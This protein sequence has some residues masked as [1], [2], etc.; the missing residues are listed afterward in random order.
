MNKS[1]CAVDS[2]IE[3]QQAE[4]ERL[5]Q[6][7]RVET[8]DFKQLEGDVLA[9]Y[10]LALVH[11]KLTAA[12]IS[13]MDA[14]RYIGVR[15][16]NT[17]Y[18]DQAA[19]QQQGILVQGIDQMGVQAVAEH[20]ISLL[21][22]IAK[23]LLPYHTNVASGRW[24]EGLRPSYELKGKTLGIIGYGKIGERVAT[25]GHALGMNIVIASGNKDHAEQAG[26]LPLEDVLAQADIVTL[27]ASTRTL[28]GPLLTKT[29]INLLKPQAIV[30][31]T[32]RGG[33]MDY[34]A[35]EDALRQGK[36]YGAG[37][38][39]FPEEPVTESRL[40]QLPNVIC[41]P[42]LAYYTDETIRL[43]NQQL[44]QRAIDYLSSQSPSL[45]PN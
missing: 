17:D 42:H 14:C 25:L 18:V 40:S 27:H 38:D 12:A 35:L 45:T 3:L 31:N 37:L 24:R 11:S 9:K 32:A 19:A 6:Y 34:A 39:V 5:E 26:R 10:E 44:I 23:Q 1:L 4:R 7:F 20:T 29:M 43:M 16:H 21:L 30:I 2:V 22:A 13:T 33:L 8:V 15:A 36:L 41:T 28:T